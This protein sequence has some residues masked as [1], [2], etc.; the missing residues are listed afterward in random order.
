MNNFIETT[1]NIAYL[2]Q[3][4]INTAMVKHCRD[5]HINYITLLADKV[6][7]VYIKDMQ[8]KIIVL[9]IASTSAP[10]AS[11]LSDQKAYGHTSISCMKMW[12][13]KLVVDLKDL[14][15]IKLHMY[16]T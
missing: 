15:L 13:Q 14:D 9:K 1:T 3:N 4:N 16:C 10:L 5:W 8:N 6:L 7:Y 12:V 11:L 2:S